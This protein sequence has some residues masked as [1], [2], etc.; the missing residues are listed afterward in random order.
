MTIFHVMLG[1][2]SR[3]AH[4]IIYFIFNLI[5]VTQNVAHPP[6]LTI[7]KRKL[8]SIIYYSIFPCLYRTEVVLL[9]VMFAF[10]KNG[11]QIGF[12]HL[13]HSG[14]LEHAYYLT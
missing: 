12:N 2:C 10:D 3:Q 8:H 7:C 4:S 11:P 14:S 13:L 9:V 5:S 1:L 6:A